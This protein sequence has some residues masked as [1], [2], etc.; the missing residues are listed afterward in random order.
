MHC[1]ALLLTAA[2]NLPLVSSSS[3]PRCTT[4]QW[5][6]LSGH[7]LHGVQCPEMMQWKS[8]LCARRAMQTWQRCVFN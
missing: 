5:H 2:N 8:Q 1:L 7:T 3:A 4:S 6:K